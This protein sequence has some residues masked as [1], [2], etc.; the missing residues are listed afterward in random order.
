METN[1][2]YSRHS[3]QESTSIESSPMIPSPSPSPPS[4]RL[5]SNPKKD[6]FHIALLL[7]LYI[8]QG[9]PIGMVGVIPFLLTQKGVGYKEQAEFSF[10]FWPFSIKLL[11]APIVD[12]LYFTKLGGRRK[13]WL[14][15]VQYAIGVTMYYL[16]SRVESM[17]EAED[18][19][20]LT[21]A[22]FFLNF[23]AAT[24]DIA[25]DGWAL[26]MLAPENVV[27]ASTC[28]SVGQTAGYFIGYVG[29][30][31]LESYGVI[32]LPTFLVFFAYVF[33]ISTTIVAIF[34]TEKPEVPSHS[35]SESS[36]KLLE[37]DSVSMDV[38][39]HN[40]GVIKTY[41][42]LY[43]IIRLE[44]MMPTM[45]VFLLTAKICFSATDSIT[46][47]KLVEAG[48]PKESLGMLALPL[49]PLQILLPLFISRYTTGPKPLNVFLKAYPFRLIMCLV[50]A[51]FVY[52]TPYFMLEDGVYPY[53]Y[54]VFLVI[55]FALHQVTS[56]SMFVSSMA[57]YSLISDPVVGGT[58]MTLLN[59][60]T[61]LGGNWP[62]TLSLW[63]VDYL[64]VKH[65]N[66]PENTPSNVTIDEWR[67]CFG[68]DHKCAK[69]GGTCE[70]VTEGYYIECFICVVFGILWLKIWG[71]KAITKLQSVNISD[72]R[73]MRK[74]K[75]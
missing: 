29:Y 63:L 43:K 72:W 22:F 68:K 26:T 38:D 7:F 10:A 41:K 62:A 31:G 12:S 36:Q 57:F 40:L 75:Y 24:Q 18:V 15:P 64:T 13:T 45:V 9:I 66:M 35:G 2:V 53:S 50:I 42:L 51:G 25:V 28:N 59:T 14:I 19:A 8:L 32:D 3:R 5:P 23:L 47:L 39:E 65:C 52:I 16:S 21:F 33:V 37:S 34:I 73:V 58:Y 4:R 69:H 61:N 17:I 60:L 55:I 46:S 27:Y 49:T 6:A 71:E 67:D 20:T 56:Y 1:S 44:V 70:T 48:V 74:Q 11:W 54:Y 30:L